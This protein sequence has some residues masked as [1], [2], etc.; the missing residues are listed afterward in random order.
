MELTPKI[1]AAIRFAAQAHLGQVRKVGGESYIVHPVAVAWLVSQYTSDEDVVAAALLHD[2]LED[3][4]GVREE[5]IVAVVGERAVSIIRE[6]TE[7]REAPGTVND[8]TTW[9]KRKQGYLA[10]L[11]RAFPG[12]L[13]IAA[14]DKL[15][16]LRSMV[17][18]YPEHGEARWVHFN[19]PPDRKLWFCTEVLAVLRHRLRSSIITEL[20][21]LY[22]EAE[23]VLSANGSV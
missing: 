18:S 13:L 6:V 5:D 15:H 20:E 10:G 4:V 8:S 11:Q 22:C 23:Q 21:Q 2:V 9:L 1:E 7:E 12:A 19:S 17:R 14:A 3:V 16:N